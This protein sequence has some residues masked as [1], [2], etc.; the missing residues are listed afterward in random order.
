M[1]V[2]GVTIDAFGTLV[3][4]DDPAPA[5]RAALAALG[6]ERELDAVRRA[7][8]AEVAYYVPRSHE[9]RDEATLALLRRDCAAVFLE[10]AGA[11]ELDPD[12]FPFVDSLRFRLLP[13]ALAASNS[14]L[15]AG[16]R[17][18]VVSNWD[19]GLRGILAGL[20]LEL[21]VFTSAAAG[22]PKPAPDVFGLA[23]A[24][25]DVAPERAVHVGDADADREGAAA[26]GM[27]F[28]PAPLADAAR[29]ILA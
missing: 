4:L 6:V 3:G 10:A 7:F 22:A 9:G 27:R 25:L 15:L 24:H 28:E 12:E 14:L 2:E 21:P 26:A 8:E 5:L 13:G 11:A 16:V 18:A 29:R 20:G 19:V 17:V 23:L 1:D